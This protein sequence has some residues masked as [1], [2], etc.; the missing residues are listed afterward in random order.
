MP[1]KD[2]IRA[3]R[4]KVFVNPQHFAEKHTWNGVP[5]LCVTDD[6]AA[7]KRKNNNVNDISWDNNSRETLVY[8]REEDWPG[9][10][11]VQP[12]EHGYFDNVFMKVLQVEMNFGIYGIVLT[13]TMPRQIGSET[14]Y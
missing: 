4:G 1:L 7:L 8:V 3:D 13:T 12:N 5:F 9:R 10:K 11:P 2:R 14:D 6:E